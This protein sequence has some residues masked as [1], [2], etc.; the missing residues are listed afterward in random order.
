QR[1]ILH[2]TVTERTLD[3]RMVTVD[4]RDTVNFGSCSTLG[5]ETHPDLIAGTIAATLR[6]G[7]QFSSSRVYASVSLYAELEGLLRELFG[8]PVVVCASTTLG[9][10]AALPTIVGDRDAV[11]VDMQAHSSMQMAVGLLRARGVKAT[12]IR[13]NDMDSLAQKIT[14]L[15]AEH[16][17]VWYIADGLYSM[18]G[19]YAPLDRLQQLL[20]AHGKFHLYIDDAHGMSWAGANGVGYVR[21]KI[22]HHER[23]VL[24]VSLNKAFAAGG[25][26]LVFPNE[27]LADLVRTC[28]GT[29]IFSGPIQ[30]PMLGAACAS[31]RLHLSG[32]LRQ[33]QARLRHLVAHTNRRLQEAGLPQFE[34]SDSPVF[35]V[36]VGAPGACVNL[37]DWM[38]RD[39]F[40]MNAAGFPATPKR[41]GG[42]RFVINVNL[43]EADIDR[44]VERLAHNYEPALEAAG[45]SLAEVAR[46]FGLPEITLTAPQPAAADRLENV[47]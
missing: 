22:A 29:S 43:R 18:Y 37:V 45:S 21:S 12:V 33:R 9:H 14:E 35:F 40:L 46:A 2:Q 44:M 26:A 24:A 5:L 27:Q 34:A 7:T 42:L 10:C 32:A 19:D 38:K 36:P 15:E 6:F 25:G 4:D 3:G 8:K 20:D 13:H 30:P 16:E 17:R 39:G 31:A 23:M 41:R 28:G 1:G 47:A 11:I